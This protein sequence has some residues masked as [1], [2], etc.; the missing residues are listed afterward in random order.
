MLL[1]HR[2]SLLFVQR[3]KLAQPAGLQFVRA[4]V[5]DH[6]RS[7]NPRVDCVTTYGRS[8]PL[9]QRWTQRANQRIKA[10]LRYWPTSIITSLGSIAERDTGQRLSVSFLVICKTSVKRLDPVVQ[11]AR[12][13][14]R[15]LL[16]SLQP[17]A[18]NES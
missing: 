4:M 16:L 9:P 17:R 18:L 14:L 12:A 13:G 6:R 10:A 1:L 2:Q 3:E 8:Q 5:D 11:Q 15:S 7:S